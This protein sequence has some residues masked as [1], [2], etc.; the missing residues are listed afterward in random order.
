MDSVPGGY[1]AGSSAAYRLDDLKR[2]LVLSL[3]LRRGRFW[4]LVRDM[5]SEWNIMPETRL[6]PPG[7]PRTLYPEGQPV[8]RELYL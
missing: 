1:R 4:E 2:D 3:F 6:P 5:R 8:F 7:E